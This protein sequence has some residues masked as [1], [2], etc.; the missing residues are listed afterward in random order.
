MTLRV[1]LA[2]DQG[3]VRSG[4]RLILESEPDIEVVGEA[5]DGAQAVDAGRRIRPDLVL[6]DI[7]MPRMDG[8]E[9]TRL[10]AGPAVDDPVPVLILTTYNLDEYVFAALRAGASGFLLKHITPDELIDAV[11]LVA[12]GEGLIA[13]AVTRRLIEEFAQLPPRRPPEPPGAY[14]SLTDRE[15]DVLDLLVR[16]RSNAQIAKD[17]FV[18][19]STVK[20]HVGKV[21]SKLGLRDRVAAV[22]WAY[23]IGLVRPGDAGPA[24]AGR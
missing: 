22:I 5:V 9:A 3:I 8:V 23:E 1:I 20:T 17:L 7:R 2:D 13:P 14:T 10:L 11:R 19:P 21:L 12:A 24:D 15:R 6:M 4:L 16:G 18:E